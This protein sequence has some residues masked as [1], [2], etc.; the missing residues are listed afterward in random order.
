MLRPYETEKIYKCHICFS[1]STK[2]CIYLQHAS[3]KLWQRR[4]TPFFPATY[5]LHEEFEANSNTLLSGN[6]SEATSQNTKMCVGSCFTWSG[7]LCSE[8]RAPVLF[9]GGNHSTVQAWS[10]FLRRMLSNQ[11]IRSMTLWNCLWP[12]SD[13]P[14]CGSTFVPDCPLSVSYTLFH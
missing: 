1:A 4:G 10:L 14:K 12:C 7:P 5:F 6:I 13:L 8:L 3:P 9:L 11:L 2:Q